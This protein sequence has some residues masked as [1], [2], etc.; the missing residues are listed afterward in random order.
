MA[1]TISVVDLR[2]AKTARDQVLRVVNE[3]DTPEVLGRKSMVPWRKPFRS[4]LD[5][6]CIELPLDSLSNYSVPGDAATPHSFYAVFFD[7]TAGRMMVL[8]FSGDEGSMLLT[9][10]ARGASL[11]ELIREELNGF[12]TPGKV[13]PA[14]SKFPEPGG[15][16]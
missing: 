13:E 12:P 6:R 15:H 4:A 14:K 2:N 8:R 7:R 1:K 3:W 16:N 10:D 5:I 11:D 9:A